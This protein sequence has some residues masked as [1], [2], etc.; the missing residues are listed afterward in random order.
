VGGA[1]GRHVAGQRAEIVD[2]FE[3]D[4]VA[5]ARLRQHVAVEPR[6]CVGAEAIE[7]QAVVADPHVEHPV[8]AQI[9]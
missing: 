5:Y 1:V 2:A 6:E 4:E 7:Q 3:E 9:R 8:R